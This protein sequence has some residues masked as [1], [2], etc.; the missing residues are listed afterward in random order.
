MVVVD[1]EVVVVVDVVVVVVVLDF[2]VP[3]RS[4]RVLLV[5]VSSGV[6]CLGFVVFLGFFVVR[7][8]VRR[9]LRVVV[10]LVV[11]VVDLVVIRGVLVV[12]VVPCPNGQ[13]GAYLVLFG[14][15]VVVFRRSPGKRGLYFSKSTLICCLAITGLS[16]YVV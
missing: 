8:V 13:T 2:E 6:L 7:L 9:G 10:L 1:V 3:A 16:Q 15:R 14:A 11:V 5:V 12:V 4:D